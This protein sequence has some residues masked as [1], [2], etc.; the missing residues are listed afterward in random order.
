MNLTQYEGAVERQR[1][2]AR[3]WLV[4]VFFLAVPLTWSLP[5]SAQAQEPIDHGP[6]PRAQGNVE[7]EQLEERLKRLEKEVKELKGRHEQITGG[8]QELVAEQDRQAA[9]WASKFD[10]LRRVPLNELSGTGE[11]DGWIRNQY[12][13]LDIRFGGFLQASFIH[14]FQD[15]GVLVDK[16]RPASFPVPTQRTTSTLMSAKSTRFIFETRKN[17]QYGRY[18]TFL[19]MDLF[20]SNDR[21]DYTMRG[22]QAYITGVSPFS[23]WSFLFGRAFSTMRNLQAWPDMF[24]REGPQAI[25]RWFAGMIRYSFQLD[26]AKH[27]IFTTAIEEPDTKVTNGNGEEDWP[28]GILRLDTNQAWGSLMI[29]SVVRQLKA[30]SL[31]NSGSDKAF[32]YGVTASGTLGVPGTRDVIK[33]TGHYGSGYGGLYIMDLFEEG[34][35]DGVY[36]DAKGKLRPLEVYGGYGI[37][38][39]PWTDT[40]RST[41]GFG[42][43]G[44]SNLAIQAGNSYKKTFWVLASLIYRPF[45]AFDMGLEYYWGQ[46]ENKDGQTGAVNRLMFSNKFYF[47]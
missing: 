9:E 35:Q 28:D 14:N 39:H 22:R 42:Y 41:A 6:P 29:A 13:N 24:G 32:G 47:N 4:M 27:W 2:V 17:T 34:G 3:S 36:D 30:T 16:F 38:E 44:V 23:G 5:Y 20:G 26:E 46:R 10:S 19:S 8:M 1:Q 31:A 43:V 21:D 37:Y 11:K 18:S 40:L 45:K 15:T 25:G 33:F 7:T 12:V